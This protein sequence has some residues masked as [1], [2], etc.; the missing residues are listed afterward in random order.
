MNNH[1]TPYLHLMRLHQP[2]GTFLL[3]WPVLWS[4]W[5]A[6]TGAPSHRLLIIFILGT[7]IMR[8]AGCVVNDIFDRTFDKQVARTKMR[9][10][11]Q[12][13][14]SVQSAWILFFVLMS[15][16]F[17]LVLQLNT[18][19][20]WI[21]CG[22]AVFTVLYPLCKRITYLPQL[23]L[24]FTFNA[25]VLLAFSASQER[26]PLLAIFLYLM[27]VIWTMAYDTLYAMV[28][29]K[30]DL[31]IGIKS[32]A[33]LFGSYYLPIITVFYALFY[34]GLFLMGIVAHLSFIFMIMIASSATWMSYHLFQVKKHEAY[35]NAFLANN[36]AGLLI[37]IGF[38]LS[39]LA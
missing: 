34:L 37:F 12:E 18:L 28:D 15:L 26:I 1:I 31:T 11:A 19:S 39:L 20:V 16:A 8:A 13:K 4:L 27:S 5:L 9:P 30:E 10:L 38:F 32:T 22:A 23:I 29:K 24:G 14:I 36:V 3:L 17:I 33:V 6:N 25:G 2:I 7:F 35:F 21:A